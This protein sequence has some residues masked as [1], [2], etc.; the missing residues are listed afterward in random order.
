V[1]SKTGGKGVSQLSRFNVLTTV[2]PAPGWRCI[3]ARLQAG[4]EALYG[5]LIVIGWAAVRQVQAGKSDAEDFL[6]LIVH[7]PSFGVLP[8]REFNQMRAG[9]GADMIPPEGDVE[10]AKTRLADH[11]KLVRANEAAVVGVPLKPKGVLK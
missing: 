9:V 2:T 10:A 1:E 11:L 4:D 5:E 6:D 3:A 7:S 8:L